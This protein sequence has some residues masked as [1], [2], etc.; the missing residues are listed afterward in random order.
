MVCAVVDLQRRTLTYASAGHPPVLHLRGCGPTWLTGS[1]GPPLTVPTRAR[2]DAETEISVGDLLVL[3][4]DGLVERRGE[5]ID[6]GLER[7]RAAAADRYGEP[8]QRFADG[9]LDDLLPGESRDDVVLVVKEVPS[10][11]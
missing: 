9:L 11:H 5:G 4:S 7:L 3:Y 6:V 8:V 2:V 10:H 1:V